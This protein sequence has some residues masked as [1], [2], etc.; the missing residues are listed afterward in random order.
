MNRL[1]VGNQGEYEYDSINDLL[2]FKTKERDYNSSLEFNEFVL[3]IDTKGDITG[4]RIFDASKVLGISKKNLLD[5]KNL[6]FSS[7][8]ERDSLSINMRFDVE[9]NGVIEKHVQNFY[10]CIGSEVESGIV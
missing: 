10:G 3:D 1:K 6:E 5:L 9:K 4:L 7:K 2:I 8:M